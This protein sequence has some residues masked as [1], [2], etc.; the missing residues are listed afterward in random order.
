L[1]GLGII[2]EYVGR[3]YAESKRRPLYYVE[4]RR[5]AGH[6]SPGHDSHGPGQ[7]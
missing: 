5:G 3:T 4:D 1:M 6:P 7:A 2:G